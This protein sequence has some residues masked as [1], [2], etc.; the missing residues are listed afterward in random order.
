MSNNSRHGRGTGIGRRSCQDLSTAEAD[1]L[2]YSQELEQAKTQVQS[3]TEALAEALAEA[4]AEVITA[5]EALVAA[6]AK[7]VAA[8]DKTNDNSSEDSTGIGSMGLIDLMA[9]TFLSLG[10]IIRRKNTPEK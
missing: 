9:L 10:V 1:A 8:E 2:T 3:T 4:Q 6:E 5:N 7:A